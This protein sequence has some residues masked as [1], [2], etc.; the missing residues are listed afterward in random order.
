MGL[1]VAPVTAQADDACPEP[2]SAS[3]YQKLWWDPCPSPS[4]EDPD[5]ELALPTPGG[6]AVV[7]RRVDTP[8]ESLFTTCASDVHS[9]SL[10]GD[11][12]VAFSSERTRGVRGGFS[13]GKSWYYYLGKYELTIAQAAHILAADGET[14]ADGR[15]A[16]GVRELAL[17]MSGS[18][19]SVKSTVAK[20]AQSL[21]ELAD[22]LER[23]GTPEKSVSIALARPVTG[24]PIAEL[25]SLTQKY[26]LWC[27]K[28]RECRAALRDKASYD[29]VPGFVRLPSEIEW[30]FAARGGRSVDGATFRRSM[31]FDSAQTTRYANAAG[32]GT[33]AKLRVIGVRRRPTPGGF[34]DLFGNGSELSI[35]YFS[36]DFG[37]GKVG[38]R[39][40]RGGHYETPA[41]ALGSGLRLETPIYLV[42]GAEPV[43]L[44]QDIKLGVRL[45]LGAVVKS[46]SAAT[47]AA[48]EEYEKLCAIGED[49]PLVIDVGKA[50]SGLKDATRA[51]PDVARLEA[52]LEEVKRELSQRTRTLCMSLTE[53]AYN[54]ARSYITNSSRVRSSDKV[55]K[56]YERLLG[57]SKTE[58]ARS[59]YQAQMDSVRK[60]VKELKRAVA[61]HLGRY[62]D[63]LSV[64]KDHGGGCARVLNAFEES[65]EGQ[66]VLKRSR[67][68]GHDVFAIVKKQAQSVISG[69]GR[70]PRSKRDFASGFSS[71]VA[72]LG[73]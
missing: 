12:S 9:M 63:T 73:R 67:P 53:S 29:D 15:L 54:S 40:A 47:S 49:D 56:S 7:F 61:V 69:H 39:A 52:N 4:A 36:A 48:R 22:K 3:E 71:L 55:L 72:R 32:A 6:G 59:D 18:A 11:K 13:S 41:T 51:L 8:G 14:E 34:Y 2:K 20:Q 43:G 62:I 27:Y 70:V 44:D 10:L 1:G 46:S 57:R 23:S 17:M 37:E 31:P 5:N 25:D 68:N 50:G 64:M 16:D 26:S 45:A 35:D 42:K 38:A 33:K 58:K 21:E 65:R 19:A 28:N 66:K 30:E 24:L 60:N